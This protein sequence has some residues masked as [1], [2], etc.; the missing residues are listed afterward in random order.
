MSKIEV[1]LTD[2]RV[3]DVSDLDTVA[4]F[5]KLREAGVTL[6]LIKETRHYLPEGTIPSITCPR[7]GKKSYN[8]HDIAEKYC[9][10]CHQFHEF[11]WR[12]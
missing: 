9:G 11:L 1:H 5:Q 6:E 12:E 10:A 2:G 7:C 3:I 8:K 4:M